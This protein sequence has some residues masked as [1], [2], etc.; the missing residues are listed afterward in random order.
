MTETFLH[1]VETIQVASE[2]GSV[3]T[4]K[5]AVIGLL[6]DSQTGDVNKLKL[7]TSATDDNHFGLM[8]AE[9]ISPLRMALYSIRLQH[10]T[11]V[12]FAINFSQGDQYDD[13]D[14]TGAVSTEKIGAR[15]FETCKST[16]GFNPKI[17]IAGI[18][19]AVSAND[20]LRDLAEKY[21]GV[22]Y[23]D[24]SNSYATT[25]TSR[26]TSGEWNFSD[27]RTKL[28]YPFVIMEGQNQSLGMSAIAAGLRAKIDVEEGFWVSSSNHTYKKI[29]SVTESLSWELNDPTCE[30]NKLNELG[31]TTIV[32]VYGSGLREWGNRNSAFP[33]KTDVR[34]FEAMQRLDDI[35][36]ESI[37]LASLPYIDRPMTKAQIDF[38]TETVNGYF[39]TLIAKGALQ[40]GSRCV[41]DASQNTVSEMANGHYVWTKDFMGAVP[42]ERFT[43]YSVI[44]TS[45]LST[46]TA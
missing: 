19:G 14:I 20:C 28:L 26:G 16:Y 39:N 42:G 22:A 2:T 17:F 40:P 37:E 31:I 1:G 36:S 3:S 41:F 21:R 27:Y 25:I 30:A 45:L 11:A 13:D 4:V 5:T 18:D 8:S 7:C 29:K 35:T 10:P 23:L 44:Y 43:F 46:L 15:L 12:V 33:T 34:T 9:S 38:V 32:N 24:G 6:G